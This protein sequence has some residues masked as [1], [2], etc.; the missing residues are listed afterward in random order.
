[1]TASPTAGSTTTASTPK[2]NWGRRLAGAGLWTLIILEVLGMGLAGL[3]K[4]QGS[5]WPA[6]F[7]G[8]GYPRGFAFFIGGA[9]FVC[10]LLLLVPRI[11]SYAAAALIVV[12]IG[13]IYTV[14]TNQ[15]QLGPGI[16]TIH[17]AVLAFLFWIRWPRRWRWSK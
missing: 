9:E 11:T 6:M 2:P 16:P 14:L 13:A 12:M 5:G 10:A 7:E 4:F 15:S 8:W 3:S 1:M 17:I